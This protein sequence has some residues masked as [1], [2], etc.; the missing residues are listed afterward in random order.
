MDAQYSFDLFDAPPRGSFPKREAATRGSD[1][2]RSA[3][4]LRP[5]QVECLDAIRS[6]LDDGKKRMLAVLATGLG[7]TVIFSHLPQIGLNRFL[8]LAHRTELLTQ[9]RASIM[10]SNPGLRVEI[11]QADN[12][13]SQYADVVVA[14]VQTLSA[15]RG[16]KLGRLLG[17]RPDA[18]DAVVVD[19]AHHACSQSYLDV[20]KHFGCGDR[21]P[22][23]GV[24]ATPF[25]GDKRNLADIFAEVVFERGLI[26][27][28]ENDW[29]SPLR[30]RRV[31]TETDL[32]NLHTRLGEFAEEE[33]AEAANT[34]YRN[35]MV[36]SAVEDHAVDRT[37]V[38]V[39]AVNVKHAE[40]LAGQFEQRGHDSA[41]VIGKTP[42][43]ERRAIFS[44]FRRGATRVL[45]G[46]EVFTEGFDIPSVDC[47]V[48]A[49]PT[50]SALLY[51]Q[52]IGRGTRKAPGK[53][54]CLVLD[55][56]DVCGRHAIQTASKVFG[57][58]ELDLLGEDALKAAKRIKSAAERGLSMHDGETLDDLAAREEREKK[59]QLGTL[60]IT[61]EAEAIDIFAESSIAEEV[62]RDS[63]FPWVKIT[64]DDYRLNIA[65]DL[66]YRLTRNALG[67]WRIDTEVGMLPLGPEDEPPFRQA[68]SF[69][70]KTSG[71]S[72]MPD[73]TTLPR[74]RAVAMNATW[75]H[76]EPTE[77]QVGMLKRLGV[78]VLPA[79]ATK[80]SVS[81]LIS[82]LM[83]MRKV[84][85]A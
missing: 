48:M 4:A 80:G 1:I 16:G 52:M 3:V 44:A 85:R 21:T 59:R 82:H 53:T 81:N 77:K 54:D 69:V 60:R 29:L 61:T 14:S 45:T 26:W 64:P 84:G 40:A 15:K 31:K 9:A 75:R 17:W 51:T 7:K 50:R 76:Q 68:D 2:E 42:A 38:L 74:W 32:S 65:R 8:V 43:D 27:G 5:Y 55:V 24:T 36:C 62:E 56:V 63:A 35:S 10:A 41:V 18:F 6:A 66:S 11:E 83:T 34:D 46:C 67:M 49:R 30:A 57:L 39:F 23:L 70:R 73:G 22:L 28:I 37:R 58:P 33:L 12:H 13:A 78:H 79:G 19:E 72:T 20:L 25:R 71:E 47:I